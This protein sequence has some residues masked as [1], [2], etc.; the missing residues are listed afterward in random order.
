MLNNGKPIQ[1]CGVRFDGHLGQV[2]HTIKSVWQK[3]TMPMQGGFFVQFV[4]DID[5]G[6]VTLRKGEGGHGNLAVYGNRLAKFSREINC[7]VYYKQ[8]V[9]DYFFG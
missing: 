1:M 6:C 7:G 4:V 8:V 3:E 2:W 5:F 9:S